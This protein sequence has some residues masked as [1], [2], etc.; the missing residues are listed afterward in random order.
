MALATLRRDYLTFEV[1][2]EDILGGIF[3]GKIGLESEIRMA[4]AFLYSYYRARLNN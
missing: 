3:D 1:N 2:D 4:V